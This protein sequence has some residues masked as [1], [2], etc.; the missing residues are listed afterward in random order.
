MYDVAEVHFARRA[1]RFVWDSIMHDLDLDY[2]E[3]FDQN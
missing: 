3:R 2:V 1:I